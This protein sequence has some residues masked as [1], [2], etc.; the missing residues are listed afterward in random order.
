MDCDAQVA[1]CFPKG[2]LVSIDY[3]TLDKGL[4]AADWQER[5]EYVET[6]HVLLSAW[7]G[8]TASALKDMFLI[9]LTS[10]ENK[11]EEVERVSYSFYCQTFFDCFG[12]VPC[13]SPH[14]PW[15]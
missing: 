9:M 5:C 8:E 13:I 10:S 12:Q 4:G 6:F 11:V 2:I 15:I 1:V 14:L 3:L 7:G